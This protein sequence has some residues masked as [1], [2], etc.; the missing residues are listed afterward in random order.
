[1]WFSP[2][3][4][5]LGASSVEAHTNFFPHW[6]HSCGFSS[7][8]MIRVTLEVWWVY[9]SLPALITCERFLSSVDDRVTLEV[10]WCVKLFPHWSHVNGSLQCGSS[11]EHWDCVCL[12][13]SVHTECRWNF[14]L[15]LLFSKETLSVC[16]WVVSPVL[17]WCCFSSI[18]SEIKDKKGKNILNNVKWKADN[19]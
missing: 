19:S 17:T 1:M 10:W 3:N 13:N 11:C 18:R 6:S 12:W 15:S 14:S 16:E 4:E 8:W 2:L 9:E 7:E 5:L